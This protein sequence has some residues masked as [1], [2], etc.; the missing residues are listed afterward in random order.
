VVA[1]AFISFSVGFIVEGASPFSVCSMCS[2]RMCAHF[3][4]LRVLRSIFL[5]RADMPGG[6]TLQQSR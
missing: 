6:A 4:W 1:S 5:P 3:Q 2:L